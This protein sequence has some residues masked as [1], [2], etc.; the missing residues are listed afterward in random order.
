MTVNIPT[1]KIKLNFNKNILKALGV[2]L[3]LIVV[4]AV[5][6]AANSK[7]QAEQSK[8]EAVA[9]V[10]VAKAAK[11]EQANQAQL[12]RAAKI[13]ASYNTLYIECSKGASIYAN[14]LTAFQKTTVKPAS[15]PKCGAAIPVR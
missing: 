15:V 4:A 11:V 3:L 5:F 13:E 12:A 10:Q 6:S 1:P 8:K 9:Q 7:Y 2:V 14:N